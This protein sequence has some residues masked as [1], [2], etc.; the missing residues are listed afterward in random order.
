MTELPQSVA[1]DERT[2]ELGRGTTASVP[3]TG[4]IPRLSYPAPG[5]GQRLRHGLR[6]LTKPLLRIWLVAFAVLFIAEVAW[7]F[8]TPLGSAP[9]EPAHLVRAASLVRGQLLGT[10]LPHPSHAQESM[11]TVEVPE[12]FAGLSFKIGCFQFKPTVPAGCELPVTGSPQ[13]V[14]IQTYVGRYPPFYYALVGL[15]TL[16]FVSAKGIYAARLVSGALSA[17]MLALAVRSLRRC[18]G[19]PLVAAGLALAVTPMVL[20]LASVV[21]PSGLEIASTISAWTA[22]MALASQAPEDVS[23]YSVG[24]LGVPIVV[25][26]LTRAVSPLWALFI[27]A[28]F[29]SIGPATSLR[30]LLRRRCVRAWLAAWA[31]AGLAALTWDVAADPFL[32]EPGAALPP[33]STGWHIVALAV[34]RLHLVLTSSIGQFGWLDTPSPHGVVVAWLGALGAVVLVGVCLSRR[35]SAAVVVSNLV[36]WVVIPLA[37]VIG[38]ARHNGILG[39][40]RDFMGLAVGI[41]IVAGFVAGERVGDRRKMLR[42]SSGIITVLAVCQMADFYGTLRR[43]TVGIKGPLDAFATVWQ[44]W[45][46]PVPAVVLV[47]VF[48]LA[49]AAFAVILSRAVGPL[50]AGG[51]EGNNLDWTV[52]LEVVGTGGC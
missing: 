22:A 20:Y 37:L 19:A 40:G 4:T 9:D 44:V 34:D 51:E 52:S 50:P 17:A 46:P 23:P 49:M 43:N 1:P 21:N 30:A 42:L 25:L 24:A 41:P 12:V 2:N 15:P 10:P 6:G 11:T 47:V 28:A 32:T 7:T 48:T 45:H 13:N 33:H 36:S 26:I 5:T 31:A 18:R 35:R 16:A 38:E 29:V 3:G 27:L 8:A 14:R 39:Q